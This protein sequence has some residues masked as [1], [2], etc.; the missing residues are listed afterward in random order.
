[1]QLVTHGTFDGR[2][3][4]VLEWLSGEPL[5]ARLNAAEHLS[6]REATRIVRALA[7][8]LSAA[9]AA[10]VVHRDLKPANVLLGDDDSVKLLDFGVARVEHAT[11]LTGTGTA[12]G[13]PGYMAPEQLRGEKVDGALRCLRPR[14]R[15][16]RVPRRQAA[17][18]RRQPRSPWQ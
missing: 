9:H 15:A 3:Y 6:E 10:G 12:L 5:D 16:L 2:P 17:V 13:T 18:R 4:S 14:L 1:M 11:A 7:S 8:A